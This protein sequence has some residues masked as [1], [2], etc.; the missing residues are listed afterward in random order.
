[1]KSYRFFVQLE[2]GSFG[3]LIV[4]KCENDERA[5]DHAR[6]LSRRHGG[7]DLWDENRRLVLATS[8]EADGPALI[9]GT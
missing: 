4:L 3:R 6:N 2:D 8:D 5:L 7:C 1:M 9:N